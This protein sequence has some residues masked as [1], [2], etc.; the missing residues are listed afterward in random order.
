VPEIRQAKGCVECGQS[1]FSGRTTIAELLVV[2]AE[3]QRLVLSTAPDAEIDMAA[4]ERGMVGMYQA[5][6]AKVW[7]G[8][9]TVEEL[10]RATR[11]E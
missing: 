2:D 10:L 4:R 5:G 6:A 8:E 1:G 7:R 3:I 9:T 11:M